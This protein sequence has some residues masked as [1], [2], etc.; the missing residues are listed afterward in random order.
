MR[1]TRLAIAA[2]P[3]LFVLLWSTGFIG[4]RSD[5]DPSTSIAATQSVMLTDRADGY[6]SANEMAFSH[7]DRAL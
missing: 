2:A 5:Q 3:A 6:E 4:A 7:I 1:L